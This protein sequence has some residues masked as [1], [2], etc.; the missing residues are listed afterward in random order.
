MRFPIRTLIPPSKS[1]STTFFTRIASFPVLFANASAMLSFSSS[2][3]RRVEYT[4][5]S[6]TLRSSLARTTYS[7]AISGKI[8]MRLLSI[9]IYNV[10][11]IDSETD[12]NTF[13]RNVFFCSFEMFGC[14]KS[15]VVLRSLHKRFV[16]GVI[17]LQTFLIRVFFSNFKRATA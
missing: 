10:F 1:S 13:A 6:A 5:A 16:Q 12:P 2:D 7:S 15:Y 8:S 14:V 11:K 4:V 3:R 9:K 17:P